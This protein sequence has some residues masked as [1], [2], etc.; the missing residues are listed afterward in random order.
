[1][2]PKPA[3][4]N[5]EFNENLLVQI[6]LLLDGAESHS[7]ASLAGA[8]RAATADFLCTGDKGMAEL[9]AEAERELR[10]LLTTLRERHA[11]R[12]DLDPA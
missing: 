4:T 11:K 10:K 12:P 1:M 5:H 3:R 7:Y 6:E 2:R 8:Y 9:A